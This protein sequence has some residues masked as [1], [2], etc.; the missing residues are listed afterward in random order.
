VKKLTCICLFLLFTLFV[1]AQ[2]ISLVG[3]FQRPTISPDFIL[4]P[5]TLQRAPS[6]KTN[7]VFGVTADIALSKRLS[8]QTG[9]LYTTLGSSQTQFYDTT[10]LYEDTKHL[11]AD[12]KFRDLS[13]NTVLH[14]AYMNIP[15]GLSLKLPIKGKTSFIIGGGP[16]FSLFFKGS[17]SSFT[18]RIAQDSI[19][20]RSIRFST[21]QADNKDLPVGSTSGK[22]RTGHFGLNA[23]A[24]L[25]FNKVS[26]VFHHY[27]DLNAFYQEEDRKYTA[28]TWGI[29]LRVSIGQQKQ[30]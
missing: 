18:T 22:Y 7:I 27:N 14:L 16:Q 2:S 10:N 28:R 20:P 25:D 5:D 30:K 24:G 13:I 4:Y 11:S 17:S 15:V 3:G 26:L 6:Q 21:K 19:S 8:L 23:F 9:V 29:R 1:S 12:K